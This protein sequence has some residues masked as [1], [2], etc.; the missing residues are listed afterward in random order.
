MELEKVK[1]AKILVED[2]DRIL[3]GFI[4]SHSIRHTAA[5]LC[6]IYHLEDVEYDDDKEDVID[7]VNNNKFKV[8]KQVRV[9]GD[10]NKEKQIQRILNL[11]C[12]YFNVT[13]KD[14]VS[15]SRKKE[16]VYARQMA[17]K[18]LR[19]NF[20]YPLVL[21]EIGGV[22]G[23]DHTTVV[24]GTRTMIGYLQVKDGYLFEI[25]SKILKKLK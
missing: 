25:H 6:A 9:P 8:I 21:K 7:I 17:M 14:I 23:R 13:M 12:Y 18:I 19:Y 5:S 16:I 4:K 10:F 15:K 3:S 20:K 22:F 1:K 2:F 11:C 24:H